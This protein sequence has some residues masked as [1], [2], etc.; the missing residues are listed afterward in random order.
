M[1]VYLKVRWLDGLSDDPIVLYHEIGDGRLESR[2]I[3]L[4][5]DG[6]LQRSDKIDEGA[7]TSLSFVP[8]PSWDEI[9]AQTEFATVEIEQAEFEQVW[10]RA[11]GEDG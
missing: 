1:S 8:F 3:E 6:R 11:R 5:E 2:R 4:F 10:N 9:K 7:Q